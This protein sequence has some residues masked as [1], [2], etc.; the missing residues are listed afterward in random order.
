MAAKGI[1]SQWRDFKIQL[2]SLAER[3]GRSIRILGGPERSVVELDGRPYVVFVP[4]SGMELTP[5]RLT[6][7]TLSW[8]RLRGR[9]PLGYIILAPMAELSKRLRGLRSFD[10]PFRTAAVAKWGTQNEVAFSSI[11]D[12]MALILEAAGVPERTV[13]MALQ[14]SMAGGAAEIAASA[15]STEP[16]PTSTRLLRQGH[17]ID[18]YRLEERLGRGHSAVVWKATVVGDI[19]GVQLHRGQTV[20]MKL[21]LPALVQGF[22]TLRIQREFAVAADLRHPNLARVYDLVL[23]PSRPH[24]AFMVMEF[25]EGTTL[26]TLIEARG[27]LSA[28]QTLRL[29]EQL[30]SALEEVHSQDALHRDVKA[31]NIMV[32]RHSDDDLTIKLVD[33][34]IVAVPS[35]ERL[36]Q[37]SVFLGSKHSAPLEQLTGQ[38]L[39]ER[40]DIYGAGSVL[41]HALTGRPMYSN[42]GPEGAIV[43][44]MLNNPERL[45]SNVDGSKREDSLPSFINRCISVKSTDRP[46]SAREC[47]AELRRLRARRP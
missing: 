18:S 11:D 21:Y 27:K 9:D 10:A 36:T 22:E 38:S 24:H 33:L 8:K 45:P 20:A 3:R 26:K 46:T 14:R 7:R 44:Q 16:A 29:G 32:P 47:L 17:V 40:T 42:A 4:T 12:D 6:G 25:I 5:S 31:A 34:G 39:D 37:A 28:S 43:V 1:A 13:V 30:F 2:V 41:F 23:S 15:D 19:S 35:E